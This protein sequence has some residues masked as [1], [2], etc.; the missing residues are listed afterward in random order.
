[1]TM[2]TTWTELGRIAG[3][4][5]QYIGSQA[6]RKGIRLGPDNKVD[7]EEVLTAIG[8]RS[9]WLNYAEQQPEPDDAEPDF[10]LER[11]RKERALR[12]L[13]E[14]EVKEKE[15]ELMRRVTVETL[16]EKLINTAKQRLLVLPGRLAPQLSIETE[17]TT[18]EEL[19]DNGIREALEELSRNPAAHFAKTR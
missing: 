8:R 17:I 14:F 3:C 1:M 10:L 2:R 19:I 4:S 15:G 6:R 18:C 12:Q 9:A 11:A 16:L 5:G 13:R 7:A